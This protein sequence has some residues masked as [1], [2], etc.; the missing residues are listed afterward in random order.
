MSNFIDIIILVFLLL[1]GKKTVRVNKSAEQRT[2][3]AQRERQEERQ[4]SAAARHLNGKTPNKQ[5]QRS[6]LRLI[7][8]DLKQ[9][10]HKLTRNQLSE[11]VNGSILY[12]LN[13]LSPRMTRYMLQSIN[14]ESQ[15]AK[16][17]RNE[18]SARMKTMRFT[19]RVSGKNKFNH[20][21]ATTLQNSLAHGSRRIRRE[22]F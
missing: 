20:N 1:M 17:A 22:L 5:Y 10:R 21:G 7:L 2:L 9:Y 14:E 13:A 12:K 3:K 19:G 11:I 18:N 6:I 8:E 16:Q 15:K 4:R